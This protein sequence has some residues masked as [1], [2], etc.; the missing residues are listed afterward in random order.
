MG[1]WNLQ[2]DECTSNLIRHSRG[3]KLG[4]LYRIFAHKTTG[5]I[6][7]NNIHDAG[8]FQETIEQLRELHSA[9][10]TFCRDTMA[11]FAVNDNSVNPYIFHELPTIVPVANIPEDLQTPDTCDDDI[12]RSKLWIRRMFVETIMNLLSTRL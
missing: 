3:S 5:H 4:S 10:D 8:A 1:Q 12:P 11:S 9:I 6:R 2:M 7:I